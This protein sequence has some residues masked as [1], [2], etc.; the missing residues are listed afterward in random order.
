MKRLAICLF[1]VFAMGEVGSGAAWAAKAAAEGS[2]GNSEPESTPPAP[3]TDTDASGAT[4][5]P[6]DTTGELDLSDKSGSEPAVA[7]KANSTLS[8]QDIAV[9]PRKRFLKGG[10]FELAPFTG[11]SVN[12]IMIRHYVFG[13]DL[14]YFLSD[15]IWVGLQGTYF[16]KQLTE[17]EALVGLQYNQIPTLNKYLYG[18]AL[19]F[20]YVPV[21]GKFAWF[22][23][24]ILHWEIFVSAGIGVTKTEIIPRNPQDPSFDNLSITPNIALG[25]RFFL[26]DWL[27]L[28]YAIRDYLIL[29]K[30]ESTNPHPANVQWTSAL[31]KSSA[32]SALVHNVMFYAGVGFYLPTKFQYKTPR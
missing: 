32:D 22:N 21:Y 18:G 16:I 1:V 11:V 6:L 28:N 30:F 26:F 13:A 31:A 3:A 10:R 5:P 14:N 2:A 25:G 12:D 7:V 20:G 29:D 4:S 19:N 27:T 8:W 23:H 15:A 24:G 17:R 9:L